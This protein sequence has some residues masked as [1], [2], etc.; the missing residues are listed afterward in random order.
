MPFNE[1]AVDLV[2]DRLLSAYPVSLS[3]QMQYMTTSKLKIQ[4]EL[5]ASPRL[6]TD[7]YSRQSTIWNIILN[8]SRKLHTH[9]RK[10]WLWYGP[11]RKNLL[12]ILKYTRISVNSQLHGSHK[13]GPNRPMA[14]ELT[15]A[16]R[17]INN[18]QNTR[19]NEY[20]TPKKKK[21]NR[22]FTKDSDFLSI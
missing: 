11:C 1:V 20:V 22:L 7:W 15:V 13:G 4:A 19:K 9:L 18:C 8:T 12:N 5:G 2:V 6:N 14:N 16:H 10:C 3:S 21:K 17:S